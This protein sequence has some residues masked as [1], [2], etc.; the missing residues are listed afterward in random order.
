MSPIVD[1][2]GLPRDHEAIMEDE[3][4]TQPRQ[5]TCIPAYVGAEEQE[6]HLAL[7]H[8]AR[9]EGA[10]LFTRTKLELEQR[11]QLSLYLLPQ[12][13]PPRPA[14]GRVVRVR[15]REPDRSDVW[16]WEIGIQFD[17]PITDYSAEI[18]DLCRR[19]RAV[20]VL[21]DPA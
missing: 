4:R 13:E 17:S 21:K 20:G 12:H 6:E 19:Q 9:P 10:L 3:R 14:V 1:D 18:E 15:R 5:L 11:V 16:L 8:D 2:E 7:I